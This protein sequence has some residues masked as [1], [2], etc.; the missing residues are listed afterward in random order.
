MSFYIPVITIIIIIVNIYVYVFSL[1]INLCIVFTHDNYIL[2]VI[3]RYG[4]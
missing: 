4:M 1:R 3:Q 2:K